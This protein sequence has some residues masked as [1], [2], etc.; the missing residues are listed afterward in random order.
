[1]QK[2]ATVAQRIS[3]AELIDLFCE[4]QEEIETYGESNE[5]NLVLASFALEL[6]K[7]HLFARVESVQ[8]VDLRRPN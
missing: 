7:R 8:S 1:M 4:T 5:L 2:K 6:V 3:D